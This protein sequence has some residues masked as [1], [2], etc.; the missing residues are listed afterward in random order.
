ME[1][2][3]SNPLSNAAFATTSTHRDEMIHIFYW[4]SEIENEARIVS[5]NTC[6][7]YT[8]WKDRQEVSSRLILVSHRFS[9]SWSFSSS[10]FSSSILSSCSNFQSQSSTWSIDRSILLPSSLSP[11]IR[12]IQNHC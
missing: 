10:S 1:D 9:S 6:D 11:F 3:M 8:R 5:Y 7:C 2:M 12:R 4:A